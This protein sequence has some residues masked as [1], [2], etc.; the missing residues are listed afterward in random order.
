VVFQNPN[1]GIIMT[2]QQT[3][4]TKFRTNYAL[5]ILGHLGHDNKL[6]DRTCPQCKGMYSSFETN[7]CGKC[8]SAL[9]HITTGN[10][11]PM[12]ISEGTIYPSFGPKQKQ[13]DADAINVRKNGME[14]VYRFKMF[15]FMDDSGAMG[16]PKEH[17]NMKKGAQVEIIIINHQA[18]PSWFKSKDGSIK[19][20]LML[21][22]Y[23]TYGDTVK[24]IHE[25][26]A[27][28]N[29]TPTQVNA[30]GNT[31][32]MDTSSIDAAIAEAQRKIDALKAAAAAA[33]NQSQPA[34]QEVI[35][36]NSGSN[37]FQAVADMDSPPWDDDPTVQADNEID[38]F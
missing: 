11:K 35:V 37:A 33:A 34:P 10:G 19:V 17:H 32:P 31:V 5:K 36:P 13:R 3:V 30:S 2:T 14:P 22:I 27:S 12:A 9:T 23:D 16:V 26:K 7:V 20:E 8:G 38:P 25:P 1:G 21:M 18:I 15:S 28:Q 24:V 29:T 4:G 6:F